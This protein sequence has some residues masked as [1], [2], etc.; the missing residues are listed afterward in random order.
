MPYRKRPAFKD[1]RSVIVQDRTKQVAISAF[2]LSG[3]PRLWL[4]QQFVLDHG[5]ILKMC[6]VH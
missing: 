5:F 2:L 4:L 3:L 6:V 1:P